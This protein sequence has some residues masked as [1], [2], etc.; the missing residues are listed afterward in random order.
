MKPTQII[1]DVCNQLEVP[2]FDVNP[3]ERVKAQ[4]EDIL[5]RK[6]I[7]VFGAGL[8][9]QRLMF[10]TAKLGIR[11]KAFIDNDP[12]KW[13]A[14]MDNVPILSP[15]DAS[16]FFGKIPI[17]IAS[18]FW[19]EIALQLQTEFSLESF[20]D[21]F[22]IHEFM[23]EQNVMR[24]GYN[25]DMLDMLVEN[26]PRIRAAID[27]LCDEDS[28]WRYYRYLYLRLNFLTP[29]RL[30]SGIFIYNEKWKHTLAKKT[31]HLPDRVRAAVESNIRNDN[32]RY[33][34][35]DTIDV[36]PGETV[37]D[38]GAWVG[39]TAIIFA[40]KVGP[41]GCVHAYE[42]NE[43][44]IKN[45][46][47]CVR[48]TEL[49]NRIITIPRGLWSKTTTMGYASSQEWD[50]AGNF[51]TENP[52]MSNKVN[53]SCID[54]DF[55]DKRVDFIKLDI[56]GSELEALT[57]GSETIRRDHPK[58]AICLY[59][60]ISDL[61]RIPEFVREVSSQYRQYFWHFGKMPTE[62]VLLAKVN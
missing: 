30:D 56:E 13:G 61:Y 51:L 52:A 20:K 27:C 23:L 62:A 21:F 5:S 16:K 14:K 32:Y 25:H 43:D 33:G 19:N 58:L 3:R 36:L 26:W 2:A 49:E 18:T 37:I 17:V 57:G 47:T 54:D 55:R 11:I 24:A 53:V 50:G 8:A 22:V 42:P 40:D 7:L 10:S 35:G 28:V 1:S 6:E 38:G 60:K 48:G 46:L 31:S 41:T 9:G 15:Q 59:H 12:G 39:D 44:N 34:S 29:E 4:F 45:V